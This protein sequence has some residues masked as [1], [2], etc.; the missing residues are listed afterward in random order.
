MQRY[1]HILLVYPEF[2]L[3][4]WGMHYMLTLLGKKATMPPLGLITIAAMTPPEYEFR[5]VDL[6][7][8]PLTEEDLAWADM[9]CFS[10]MLTQRHS[11][12]AAGSQCRKA[13]KLVV[14]GGPFPT[15]CPDE[16]A[17]YCDVQVLN[18][19]EVTWPLF[20]AD[21]E[22]GSYQ[23]L[24]TTDEKP[25]LTHTPIPRFD[26]LKI[27]DYLTVPIQFSRGC[28]F[29]CEFC[30][31]IVMFGRRPRTK[32]PEQVCAEL[33]ALE[34][35]GFRGSIFIVDDNFIG[36]KREVKKLLPRLREWNEAHNM[37]F[38]FGT[39]ASINL[40]DDPALLKDMVAAAFRWVFIGIETPSVEGLKETLKFQNTKRSL[41]G[42]VRA[43]Q[44]AGLFV[45]G[46]FIVGFDSDPEDI[47]DRQIE[48]INEAAIAFAVVGLMVALPGTP[49]YRRLREAGRLKS[50]SYD[51]KGD[52]FVYTNIVTI[53]PEEKLL[54]GYRRVM[55]TIYTPRA[56]FSRAREAL[57][58]LP[59]PASFRARVRY[60]L[61]VQKFNSGLGRQHGSLRAQLAIAYRAL[62]TLPPELRREAFRFLRFILA[63][64]PEM[65]PA[66]LRV[67]F[68]GVHLCR[69]SSEW[70][71]PM[72]DAQLA[73]LPKERAAIAGSSATREA[74]AGSLISIQ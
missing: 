51:S 67:A 59:R 4:Y 30:D 42:S 26:L 58:R 15:A 38:S 41:L 31:I 40:A 73:E 54:A 9:V 69:F 62:T 48:F 34:R 32:T 55:G 8:G 53:L 71:L 22:R 13:G 39:E 57:L 36:N 2:P 56:F 60:F 10:A 14:F 46:G 63:K 70:V 35:T 49:L 5:L 11:L 45:D 3:T 17:P 16:C 64:R 1:R 19:A 66:A 68:F 12:F 47:F 18:E 21:L 6:N 28:P 52:N 20:L 74:G 50:I 33:E 72:L 43:I 7:C 44:D 23:A 25:D 24:Y 65:L 29:L 37:P 27:D 61:G